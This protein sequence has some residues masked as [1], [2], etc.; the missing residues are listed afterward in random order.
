MCISLKQCLHVNSKH[1]Q[2]ASIEKQ[3]L[4]TET[5]RALRSRGVKSVICGLS[6]N[7]M[8]QQFKEAGADAFLFKPFPCEKEALSVELTRVL[9]T[10]G[11]LC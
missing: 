2:M 3:L 8:E 11:M 4:G 6:A 5:V 7:D 10:R 1:Q 9:K